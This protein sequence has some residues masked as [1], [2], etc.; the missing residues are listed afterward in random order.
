MTT[1]YKNG[2]VFNGSEFT[3]TD[4]LVDH[5]R[6]QAVGRNL[7]LADQVVNLKGYYVTPGLVN[8][9]THM[10]LSSDPHYW[11]DKPKNT[12]TKTVLALHNL[13]EALSVGVTY[14]RDVGSTA[15]VDLNLMKLG[16][17]NLPGIVGSGRALSMTGGHGANK[18]GHP[19]EGTLECD[20]E[21]EVRKA[22]RAVLRAGARN[23]KLMATGGVACPGETPFDVQFSQQEL[24]AAVEEAHHK[25]FSTAAHAQG[26]TGI[27]NAVL[28]GIDSIEHAIYV[29]D[30]TLE[31]MKAHGTFVVP[32]LVA[33]LAIY[34]NPTELPEFMVNK[35]K[36]VAKDH[37]KSIRRVVEAGIPVAM[38]TDAGTPYNTFDHWVVNELKMYLTAGMSPVQVLNSATSVAAKLLRINDQIGQVANNFEA[39]FVVLKKNPL[40]D[41]ASFEQAMAV[42]RKGKC[43]VNRLTKVGDENEWFNY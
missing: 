38:G 32:T 21:A 22:A 9:H 20:G 7:D 14:V 23:V 31:L 16:L 8:A 3:P 13:Q 29:D 2:L 41:F 5:G 30:E 33:P 27:K 10:T 19:E 18:D 4:F 24:R 37:L 34:E 36:L 28:A 15:N 42:F 17:P 26:T 1:L 35:A 25:G 12:V 43:V 39:N 40:D 11:D 6:F